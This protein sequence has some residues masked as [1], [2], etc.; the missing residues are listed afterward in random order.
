MDAWFIKISQVL[1]MSY[2]FLVLSALIW[3][4][5]FVLSRGMHDVIPPFGLAFYRWVVA[6]LILLPFGL[7]YMLKQIPELKKNFRYLLVQAVLGIACFNTMIYVAT[8]TTTAINAV[9][10]N[11]C[12]PVIIVAV[13]WF[14]FRDRVSIRQAAG[15]IIS[16]GGVVYIIA[17][18]DVETLRS[19]SFNRGDLV[20]LVA[21]FVWAAYSVN[22]K[23]FP[24]E[25]NP[26]AYLTA[27]SMI[28]VLILLPFY[29]HETFGGRPVH[30]NTPTIAS[31]LYVG[32]F[33]SVIAFLFWNK[34]VRDVGA[35]KAGPFVHLMPVF[36]TILA[37]I[38]LGES[39]MGFH[40]KGIGFIFTGILLTTLNIGKLRKG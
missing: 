24:K 12:I 40:L 13:S 34:A 25:L 38:F 29:L 28:G 8:Q 17:K 31:V 37:V 39:L 7:P 32:L 1:A 36:S 5:N 26:I 11:S 22:L 23:K 15:I 3:S 30:F 16:L 35:N 33:A 2:L 14:M 10:V 20:V 21:A 4:G 6:G 9:L 19:L 27:I 18:G